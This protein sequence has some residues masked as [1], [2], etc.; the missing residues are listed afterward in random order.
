M[1][2]LRLKRFQLICSGAEFGTEVEL[3]E[4]AGGGSIGLWVS[5]GDGFTYVT[6]VMGVN[7]TNQTLIIV[8]DALVNFIR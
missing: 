4:A 6:I 5:H 7:H 2:W 3:S 8:A 1:L